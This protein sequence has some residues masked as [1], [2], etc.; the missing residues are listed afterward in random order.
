MDRVAALF[1]LNLSVV[2]AEFQ[3]EDL[4]REA[5]LADEQAGE[6]QDERASVAR[7]LS[8]STSPTPRMPLLEQAL[9]SWGEQDGR[10]E[11]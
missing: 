1:G 2:E 9:T 6:E 5:S 10:I 8:L 7:Q 11:K 3:K 4:A